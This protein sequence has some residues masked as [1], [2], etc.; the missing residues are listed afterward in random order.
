MEQFK[1][2]FKCGAAMFLTCTLFLSLCLPVE[3]ASKIAKPTALTVSNTNTGVKLSWKKVSKASG[4][5]VYRKT[6]G[7]YKKIA[8]I[9]ANS[10]VSYVDKKASNGTTYT[11]AVKAYKKVDGK[12]IYLD[13]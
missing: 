2:I 5:Y 13:E 7:K 3:A 9:K 11:Y 1:K 12:E 8:T 6:S 4:Y 10:T